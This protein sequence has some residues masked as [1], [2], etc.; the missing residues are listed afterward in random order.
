MHGLVKQHSQHI[1]DSSLDIVHPLLTETDK[2][3][4]K[5]RRKDLHK[6]IVSMVEL[7]LTLHAQMPNTYAAFLRGLENHKFA[8]PH[9]HFRPHHGLKMDEDDADNSDETS[10]VM[11][12][13]DRPLD[14]VVEPAIMRR[15]DAD[16]EDY[17]NKRVLVKGVVWMVKDEDLLGESAVGVSLR[18]PEKSL[19]ESETA[20]TGQNA[21]T[22]IRASQ[23]QLTQSQPPDDASI[24]PAKAP[25]EGH[26]EETA[27]TI[28]DDDA[29]LPAAADS[30]QPLEDV[31]MASQPIGTTEANSDTHNPPIEATINPKST[32]PAASQGKKRSSDEQLP[33]AKKQR[34]SPD[35]SPKPQQAPQDSQDLMKE[36]VMSVPKDE[37]QPDTLRRETSK[38]PGLQQKASSKPLPSPYFSPEKLKADYQETKASMKKEE[39]AGDKVKEEQDGA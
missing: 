1:L 37:K 25:I 33:P 11:K 19:P 31:V 36:L 26:N 13:T 12:L 5:T 14:L 9:S 17:D 2:A 6:Y 20:A 8:L 28:I 3:E 7:S 27:I 32:P 10:A 4:Q 18:K 16:G 35:S 39:K 30:K 24:V 22:D 21:A 29:G 23:E 34:T 15:G 38:T